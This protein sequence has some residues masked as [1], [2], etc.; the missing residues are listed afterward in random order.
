MLFVFS[1][2]KAFSSLSVFSVLVLM[3]IMPWGGS[4]LVKSAWCPAGFLYLSGKIFFEI[5]EIFCYYLIEYITNPSC[6]DLFLFFNTH[7]SQVGFFDGVGEF[8]HIPFTTL[9]LFD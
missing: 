6:L 1:P 8:L 2:L 4:I 5:W 9:E 3:I 7:G